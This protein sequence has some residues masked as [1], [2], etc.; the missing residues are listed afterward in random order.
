VGTIREDLSKSDSIRGITG[1]EMFVLG[2]TTGISKTRS[3]I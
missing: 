1:L 2:G 3:K